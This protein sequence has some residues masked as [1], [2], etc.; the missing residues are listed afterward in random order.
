MWEALLSA[1]EGEPSYA[2]YAKERESLL[3]SLK[4]RAE[5]LHAALCELRGVTCNPSEGALYA[6][7]RIR[8]PPAALEV[9]LCRG[10]GKGLRVF[11]NGVCKCEPQ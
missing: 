9:G 6:M 5:K 3:A 8:L 1:Q 10:V 11:L 7:P 4:R 2:L